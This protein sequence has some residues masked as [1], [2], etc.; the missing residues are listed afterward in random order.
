MPST[1]KIFDLPFSLPMPIVVTLRELS[2]LQNGHT[3]NLRAKIMLSATAHGQTC[4]ISHMSRAKERDHNDSFIW[5]VYVG[6]VK[7]GKITESGINEYPASCPACGVARDQWK[8][9]SEGTRAHDVISSSIWKKVFEKVI[10][11]FRQKFLDEISN[12]NG[13]VDNQ[14]AE[15]A[16]GDFRKMLE[17]CAIT[18]APTSNIGA[19]TQGVRSTCKECEHSQG[20]LSLLQRVELMAEYRKQGPINEELAGKL[21]GKQYAETLSPSILRNLGFLTL[22]KE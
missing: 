15:N 5:F 4:R 22:S 3:D 10:Q 8:T 14:A 7:I 19:A 20:S 11:H 18:S 1:F 16:V 2:H 21:V 6:G 17:K 13:P 9:K 12:E